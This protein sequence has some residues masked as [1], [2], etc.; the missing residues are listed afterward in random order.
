LRARAIAPI[1]QTDRSV[2]SAAVSSKIGINSGGG[3][4]ERQHPPAQDSR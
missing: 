3:A 4:V 1:R 2:G